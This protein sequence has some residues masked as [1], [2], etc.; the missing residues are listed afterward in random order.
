MLL[1][2]YFCSRR[3]T[4]RQ[5]YKTEETVLINKATLSVYLSVISLTSRWIVIM[6]FRVSVVLNRTFVDRDRRFDNMCGR[7]SEFY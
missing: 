1:A 3:T 7:Q 2:I 4:I 6:I 5:E